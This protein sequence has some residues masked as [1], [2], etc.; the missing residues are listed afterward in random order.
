MLSN[1]FSFIFALPVL[2]I[3]SDHPSPPAIP[4]VQ[5]VFD[6]E[7]VTIYWDRLAEDSVDPYT[8]YSDF[9]GYRIF[10]STDGGLT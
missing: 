1:L 5:A 10:R 4:N 8:G 3:A 6:H 7:S 9:E 2:I